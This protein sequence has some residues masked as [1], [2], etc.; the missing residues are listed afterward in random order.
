M[1][2]LIMPIFLQCDLW[3]LLGYIFDVP[4]EAWM[5]CALITMSQ[6]HVLASLDSKF[7]HPQ[8]GEYSYSGLEINGVDTIGTSICHICSKTRHCGPS[9]RQLAGGISWNLLEARATMYLCRIALAGLHIRRRRTRVRHLPLPINHCGRRGM[10]PCRVRDESRKK[11][12]TLVKIA[13][14]RR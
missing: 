8:P 3:C 13:G 14:P 12:D 1:M 10:F 6:P 4:R 2:L 11:K 5:G 7:L 9:I